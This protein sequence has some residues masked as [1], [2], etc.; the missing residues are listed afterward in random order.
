MMANQATPDN[1]MKT[2]L[3]T[4]TTALLSPPDCDDD[5]AAVA[6]AA[7]A[8][9]VTKCQPQYCE[10]AYGAMMAPMCPKTCG[11]CGGQAGASTPA[12][13]CMIAPGPIGGAHQFAMSSGYTDD[14]PD[15]PAQQSKWMW[16]LA[17]SAHQH[18]TTMQYGSDEPQ[19]RSL[20]KVW[21]RLD[22]NWKRMDTY[23]Q[24]GVL[25]ALGQGPCDGSDKT[26]A[27]PY[28]CERNKRNL[29][30]LHRNNKMVFIEWTGA[31]GDVNGVASCTATD[32]MVI[33]NIRPDWYMDKRGDSTDV[34]YLG[35]Q[36][37]MYE[38]QPRLVKQWRKQDFADMMFTM[39]MQ[40][41]PGA[42]G[43]HWPLTRNDPGEGFGDD[44]LTVYTNHSLLDDSSDAE[45]LLDE[46]IQKAGSKCDFTPGDGMS[47]P[48]TG[49]H[50]EIPSNL[51]KD[52]SFRS[53]V[54]T[55]SPVWKAQPESKPGGGSDQVWKDLSTSVQYLACQNAPNRSV[56]LSIMFDDSAGVH[57]W[58]AVSFRKD[59]ECLMTPKSGQDGEVLVALFSAAKGAYD[60][61][62]GPMPK[63]LK[64]FGV[65]TSGFVQQLRFV[66]NASNEP[67]LKPSVSGANGKV[68]VSFT[69]STD[70]K[71]TPSSS[72]SLGKF[73]YAVGNGALMA[74]HASRG[75]FTVDIASLP[76]CTATAAE[77][78]KCPVCP[79]AP[80]AGPPVPCERRATSAPLPDAK[81]STKMM[82]NSAPL[83]TSAWGFLIVAFS[84][85]LAAT[86]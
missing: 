26:G 34:Q 54:F 41:I 83:R 52:T 23:S 84:S 4:S 77:D 66:G 5:D 10:G 22:K 68:Q 56:Q 75:C 59:D 17:W 48:P 11:K 21:Y 60:L 39:S 20:S 40:A 53:I 65:D 51:V 50:D 70:P 27:E 57:P 76:A 67:I 15:T 28:S 9:G 12:N 6:K 31:I 33:G 72:S 35:N 71:Q 62:F 61:K 46:Q 74:Y 3:G 42:D 63:S 58:A 38:G 32:L 86:Y 73:G 7:G 49:K 47:G 36:H 79:Q 44:A 1:I 24:S 19:Y 37:I 85:L 18:F 78:V 45:F 2:C 13:N 69:F 14:C 16:P 30:M 8:F 64:N 81:L 25:R 55:D 82:S 29:T 43:I 80:I